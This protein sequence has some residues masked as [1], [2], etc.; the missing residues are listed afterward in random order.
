MQYY[1][2]EFLWKLLSGVWQHICC[3]TVAN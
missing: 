2:V 3:F 1:S